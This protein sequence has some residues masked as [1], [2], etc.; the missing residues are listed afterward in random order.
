MKKLSILIIAA[1]M[2]TA[3]GQTQTKEEK[4]EETAKVEEQ[5]QEPTKPEETEVWEPEPAP[6][7]F[8]ANNVPSDAVVLFDG[9][10][11]DAWESSKSPGEAAG[12]II[13]DDGSMSVKPGTGDIQTKAKFGSIQLHLEWKAPAVIEGEGQGRGNSGVFF[14]NR[15]EVQ[16][17]D[18]YQNRTYSN[19]QATSVYKQH[20]PLVNATK[21]NTEWQTY[22]IIFHEPEFDAEGNKTRSGTFTVI[23][24]GV[25]VQDHVEI[26]GTTEYIGW[27]KNAAH[28]KDIIKLQDHSNPVSYRNIW[29]REL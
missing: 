25:L 8:N 4:Q 13:N 19:G 23:H 11:L 26:Q 7:S 17:L 28:G 21:P 9:T 12:W 24:N 3:C 6:I 14:Q 2:V 15:Y 5:K 22:D 18:S 20:I 16:I 27:P 29:V 10:S 1:I